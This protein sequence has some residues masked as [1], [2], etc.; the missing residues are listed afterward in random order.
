MSTSSAADGHLPAELFGQTHSQKA[1][2]HQSTRGKQA[3]NKKI[4]LGTPEEL[5]SFHG[6]EMHRGTGRGEK[7]TESK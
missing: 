2:S 3:A 4:H 5:K 6:P 1:G 7:Q